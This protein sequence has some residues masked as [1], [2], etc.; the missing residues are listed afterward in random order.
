MSGRRKRKPNHN[1][2]IHNTTENSMRL[3]LTKAVEPAELDIWYANPWTWIV[4]VAVF[5][6]FFAAIV[7]GDSRGD[8]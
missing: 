3:F 5:I 6:L 2:S 4:G 8:R 1:F 7:R